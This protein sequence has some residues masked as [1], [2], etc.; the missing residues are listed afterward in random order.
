MLRNFI[1]PFKTDLH[2]GIPSEIYE[3]SLVKLLYFCYYTVA[4]PLFYL[5]VTKNLKN[6]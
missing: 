5:I 2:I 3:E 1:V 6:A 4:F